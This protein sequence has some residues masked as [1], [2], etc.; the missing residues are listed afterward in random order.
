MYSSLLAV[1]WLH[2]VLVVLLGIALTWSFIPDDSWFEDPAPARGT[3]FLLVLGLGAG[4]LI[5]S[6]VLW[7]C[8]SGLSRGERARL[9]EQM[10][11]WWIPFMWS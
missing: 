10:L 11:V 8:A 5:C 3:V 4:S 1:V 7:F 6:V 9:R 2:N